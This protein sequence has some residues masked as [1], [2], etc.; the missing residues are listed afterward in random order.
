VAGLTSEEIVVQTPAT[1]ALNDNWALFPT[2]DGYYHVIAQHSGLAMTATSTQFGASVVQRA[3]SLS[4]SDDWCFVPVGNSN[5]E[6]R[7]RLSLKGLDVAEFS[8]VVGARVQM[9]PYQGGPNQKFTVVAVGPQVPTPPL[10]V[11]VWLPP[12]E[13]KVLAASAANLPDGRILMWAS[14]DRSG[15]GLDPSLLTWTAIFNP[16]TGG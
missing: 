12:V 3:P 16:V 15:F 8:Q 2:S 13:T 7:N 10:P 1:S 11:Q 6:V 9:W 14:K 4:A 5:Y